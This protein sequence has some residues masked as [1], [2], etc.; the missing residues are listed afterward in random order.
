M[1]L[2]IGLNFTT[3]MKK[4]MTL[5][6]F[7]TVLFSCSK[8]IKTTVTSTPLS[9]KPQINTS[10]GGSQ[11]VEEVMVMPIKKGTNFPESW[12]G[13]WVGT[14]DIYNSK[15]KQQSIPM[16]CIMSATDTAGVFN[17]NIIYGD[18]R[19]K[20]LR[21]Y[22]LRTIDASKGQY[23]CDELNTIKM[24]SYLLGNKLFCYFIVE[25]NVIMSTYEKTTD[26]K[27]LFEIIF[28]KDKI[29]SE[30]GNQVFKGDTIPVVKTFPVVISQRA[31]LTKQ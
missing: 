22:L 30:T 12:F 27:M 9:T 31:I 23:V 16:E 1:C 4:L 6:V 17:W 25:G 7:A 24:E 15:G 28:G 29:V 13:N 11:S 21:P 18:D 20:G 2:Y 5:T 19:I 10:S 8:S 3:R 26:G 14:L